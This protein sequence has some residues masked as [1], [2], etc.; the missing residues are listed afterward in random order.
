M[1]QNKAALEKTSQRKLV[2]L[3]GDDLAVISAHIQD[4][5]VVAGDILWRQA[6]NRLVVAMRRLDCEDIIAGDC[7]PRRL[8]SALRFDRVLSCRSRE[9]D[10]D[11]PE[12][13]LT[14]LGLEFHP[15]KK[16]GGEVMLLFASG[17]VLRLDVECLECELADLGPDRSDT[18]PAV[19][20][21]L[22]ADTDI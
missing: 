19:E 1:S 10:M 2:A 7:A 8:I 21:N 11:A 4:A 13:P 6:E 14:L 15:G 16:P 9:I 22:P 20:R 3:D 5:A 17:G 12:L 18:D